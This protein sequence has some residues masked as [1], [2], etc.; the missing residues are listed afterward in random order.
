MEE[1]VVHFFIQKF[2]EVYKCIEKYKN[3]EPS[4]ENDEGTVKVL[5]P[6]TIGSKLHA[7]LL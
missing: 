4:N 6:A 2:E 7:N 3:Q 1:E 5:F